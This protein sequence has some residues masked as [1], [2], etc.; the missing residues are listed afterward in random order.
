VSKSVF[1][2]DVPFGQRLAETIAWC[3]PL[4]RADEPKGSLRG[5]ALQPSLLERDRSSAL[6]S[7][8]GCRGNYVGQ[9]PAITDPESLLGGKLLV[10]FPD[11]NLSDGT[12]QLV[13]RGFFDVHNVP[14]WD[15]WIALADDA[16]GDPSFEQYLVCWVP[17]EFIGCA[18]EGIDANP[19]GCIVWLEDSRVAA[20]DELR[21]LIHPSRGE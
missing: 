15:T 7:V 5:E 18:Q 3:V 11:A 8:T 20:R 14:P 16:N 10:Y 4:V 9:P 17:P 21:W 1:D 12:A 19:E 6:R 2:D 13:S